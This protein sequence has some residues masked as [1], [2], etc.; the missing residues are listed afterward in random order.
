MEGFF[1]KWKGETFSEYKKGNFFS[2]KVCGKFI[3][4]FIS[5]YYYRL[6][7]IMDRMFISNKEIEKKYVKIEAFLVTKEEAHYIKLNGKPL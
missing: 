4:K 6:L 3:K 7:K 1:R 5:L 2:K